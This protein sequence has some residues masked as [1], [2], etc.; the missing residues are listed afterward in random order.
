MMNNNNDYRY[1]LDSPRVTGRR[2]QKTTCPQ[3][4]RRHCFVR[5]VDTQNNCAYVS[6]TCGRCDHEQ[7]CGYHLRPS[8]FFHDHPWLKPDHDARDARPPVAQKEP[9]KKPLVPLPMAYVERSMECGSTFRNWFTDT[10]L[11]IFRLSEA[12]VAK[13]VDDYRLGGTRRGDVIYWQIDLEGRVRSGHIMRYRDD[14]H[15]RDYQSWVHARLIRQKRLPP[16]FELRQCF[17]GEHLLRQRPEA[18][19]GL[20]EGEKTALLM[21]ALRPDVVWLA[22]SGCK[23]LTPDKLAALRG[24]RVAVFPDSGCYADWQRRLRQAEGV[25][26]TITDALEQFPPNTDLAD[27]L[28]A[29]RT[30]TIAS[31]G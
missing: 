21:A 2:Q 27:L 19:V 14:G 3:C 17:F 1:R 8:E 24:R 29:D 11:H 16:D 22:A 7:S 13:V 18:Q 20:V 26:F 28:L 30:T 5:Y 9:Q 23:G 10:C 4:G 12:D 15:R 31:D 6:D 25:S